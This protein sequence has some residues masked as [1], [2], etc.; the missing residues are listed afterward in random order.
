MSRL[1]SRGTGSCLPSSRP[2]N[3][4]PCRRFAAPSLALLLPSKTFAGSLVIGGRGVEMALVGAALDDLGDL[5]GRE[6]ELFVR[7]EEVRAEA[8]AGVGPEVADD[9]SR[10]ELSVDRLGLWRADH[11]RAAAAIRV[12]RAQHL[13]AG[14]LEQLDE[15]RR[16]LHRAL[17]DPLDADLLDELV[18]RGCGVER[19]YVW[20]PSQEPGR[21]FSVV[22]L[23]L[24]RER[25]RVR[26][27]TGEGRLQPFG[28]IGAD[29]EPAGPRPAAEPLDAPTDREVDAE[30][31]DVERNGARGL[32]RVEHDER[33]RLVRAADDRLDVLD[34][35]G[36]EEDVAERD[37]QRPLVDRVQHTGDVRGDL[38][39]GAP[40]VLS[41]VEVANRG[42][43][44]FAVDDPV[45]RRLE[46]EAG[47]H[48]RLRDG[49]V[50]VHRHRP[51]RR[52][53]DLS[54]LVS[55]R[56]RRLPPAFGPCAHASLAPLARVAKQALLR[57]DGHR[58]QRMVDQ[59]GRV[60]EDRKAVAVALEWL[61]LTN[62]PHAQR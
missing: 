36:L 21:A 24:E 57:S 53:D 30:R 37:E 23:G 31:G 32:V 7:V 28:E 2:R 9:L 40:P 10:A 18:A 56:R 39:L 4:V 43:L 59:V 27:P 48:D 51:R 42:K 45:A 16:L 15:Q 1:S 29:V 60:L 58:A 47:E 46:L 13:E 26:L 33:S 6:A 35:S 8:N 14:R 49:D 34:L 11:D 62:V 41:L 3:P 25:A 50:L 22:L 5:G 20:G 38:D 61:H 17:T 12:A 19:R 55:D 54:Q 52:A 44:P